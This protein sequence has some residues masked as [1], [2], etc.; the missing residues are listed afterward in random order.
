[1]YNTMLLGQVMNSY[2]NK[3]QR[4]HKHQ[5]K[6]NCFDQMFSRHRGIPTKRPALLAQKVFSY[7]RV[8]LQH[9]PL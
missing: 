4:N 3:R 6:A 9:L 8:S 7:H 2:C 5:D 1:M